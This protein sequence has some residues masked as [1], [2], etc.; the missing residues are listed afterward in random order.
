MGKIKCTPLIYNMKKILDL[1]LNFWTRG[2]FEAIGCHFGGLI[3]ISSSTLNR[4]DCCLAKVEVKRNLCGFVPNLIEIKDGMLGSIFIRTMVCD[5]SPSQSS[6]FECFILD[7]SK[8]DNSLDFFHF[9]VVLE[10][11]PSFV[12]PFIENTNLEEALV[13]DVLDKVDQQINE[14]LVDETSCIG[15]CFHDSNYRLSINDGVGKTVSL[16]SS[17]F[18]KG[19]DKTINETLVEENSLLMWAY[20][21]WKCG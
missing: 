5:M 3:S 13:I 10:D 14:S 19:V 11:E 4:L 17:V 6:P 16:N 2:C 1:H 15:V 7:S 21:I 20:M 12:P 18:D 8:L 9:Q